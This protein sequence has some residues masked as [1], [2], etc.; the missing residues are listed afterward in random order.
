MPL[1]VNAGNGNWS[2]KEMTNIPGR[3]LCFTSGDSPGVCC[4]RKQ[5]L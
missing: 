4:F 2:L 1:T 3:H 5:L